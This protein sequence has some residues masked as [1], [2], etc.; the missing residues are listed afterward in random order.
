MQ[1]DLRLAEAEAALG[2]CKIFFYRPPEPS[3]VD[4]PGHAHALAFGDDAEV[5]GQRSPLE[6]W[7]AERT[8]QRRVLVSRRAAA[9]PGLALYRL[10]QGNAQA[11]GAGLRRVLA[12]RERADDRLLV[13]GRQLRPSGSF[14]PAFDVRA[15]RATTRGSV[16]AF[17]RR[18]C[19]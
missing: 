15:A 4:Q 7:P 8:S 18:P 9:C 1:A 19:A 5:E 17:T 16:S 10:S 6:P 12:E 2:E 11:A 14:Y 3:G 13:L